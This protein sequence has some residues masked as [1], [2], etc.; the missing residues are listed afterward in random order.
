MT[1]RAWAGRLG[2]SYLPTIVFFD[3]RGDEVIRS[4]ALF[5]TFHTQSMMDYVLSG[6]WREEPSFQRY[7]SARAD[8]I[9][10]RGNRR[11]H[12]ALNEKGSSRPEARRPMA[13]GAHRSSSSVAS[14]CATAP[15]SAS[16]PS[17]KKCPA[18]GTT[19]WA[20]RG[21]PAARIAARRAGAFPST[22]G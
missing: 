11:R 10:A 5:K 18:P 1:A 15:M 13:A 22:A 3:P 17:R 16:S 4:E 2:V 7:V 14:H 6:A 8:G 12:L 20:D 21:F 19:R 9:R